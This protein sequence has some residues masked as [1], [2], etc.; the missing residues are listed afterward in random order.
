MDLALMNIFRSLI[1]RVP[2]TIP[3]LVVAFLVVAVPQ[4]ASAQSLVVENC[5]GTPTVSFLTGQSVCVSGTTGGNVDSDDALVCVVPMTGGGPAD[6]VTPDGCNAFSPA[7]TMVS[8]SIWSPPTDPGGYIVVLFAS[9]E[10]VFQQQ[11]AIFESVQNDHDGDGNADILWRNSATGQNWMY[12]MSGATIASSLGVNTVA[13]LDWEIVGNG[14]YDGDGNA[15]ILWRNSATGQNW[16]YLM[17]GATIASSLGV[18]TVASTD[19]KIVGNGDYDGDGKADILWRNSVTGQN[20][21]YLMNGATI[22][23]SLGVNTVASPDWEIVGNGDYDG[24]GNADILWRNSATGQNW[25]YLMTG[26]T[27]A[28]SLG[29]NNV[30]V[31]WKIVAEG[32]YDGD[33]NADILWRNSATGQ[34]W[35]YLMNSNSIASSVGVNTVPTDWDI[36]NAQ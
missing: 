16:M 30:P 10:E 36:V 25:M 3:A 17:S 1:S 35:M 8:E 6:D 18:N 27:I 11:I 9:S 23:S 4:Q 5:S 21:M 19:W 2:K 33:G 12:L 13:S 22:G 28:S 7:T 26:A 31:A 15:D 24:D 29:V 34:N 20:W 14:D 32:D